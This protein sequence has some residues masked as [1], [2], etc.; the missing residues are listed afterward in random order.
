MYDLLISNASYDRDNGKFECKVKVG[1]S[2]TNLHEQKYSLTVL[3]P[4]QQPTVTPGTH[5]TV[6]EGQHQELTCSSVGGSPDPMV[7]WY[8]DGK[9]V[10]EPEKCPIGAVS[11]IRFV[12]ELLTGEFNSSCLELKR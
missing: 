5:V 10:L 7:R 4:P 2:G 1:G 8:R 6:T 9:S 12:S 11:R 3:T